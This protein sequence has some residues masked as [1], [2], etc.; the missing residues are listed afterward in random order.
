MSARILGALRVVVIGVEF[1]VGSRWIG[2][3]GGYQCLYLKKRRKESSNCF[4]LVFSKGHFIGCCKG[5]YQG[6][7]RIPGVGH[8]VVGLGLWEGT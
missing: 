2:D 8:R 1:V 5:C 3:D 6:V 7:P 4:F